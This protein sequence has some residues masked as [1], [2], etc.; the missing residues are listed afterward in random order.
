MKKSI[1]TYGLIPLR[2]EPREQAEMVSQILFGDA[3]EVLDETEKWIK[4]K[5]LD[6][7]Y[8]GWVDHKLVRKISEKEV[9][10]WIKADKWIV[11]GP[12]VRV[13][14]EPEKH[15]HIITGGSSI[16]FSYNFV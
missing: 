13:V 8:E 5:L 7:G 12:F 11:P 9:D 16:F 3:F 14:S 6:D 10:Q 15:T 4:V 2:S 1:C